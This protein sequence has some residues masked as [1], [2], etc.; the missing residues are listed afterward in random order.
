MSV[1]CIAAGEAADAAE[2]HQ[3]NAVS[4]PKSNT[5]RRRRRRRRRCQLDCA[6]SDTPPIQE[7]DRV[8]WREEEDKEEEVGVR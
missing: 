4:A 6:S 5:R 2:R 7:P 8:G 1:Y 3:S